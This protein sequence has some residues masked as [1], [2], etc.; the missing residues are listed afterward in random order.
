[1]F[2]SLSIVAPVLQTAF[3][4][5]YYLTDDLYLKS[6]KGFHAK[7]VKARRLKVSHNFTQNKYILKWHYWFGIYANELHYNEDW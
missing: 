2:A 3:S 6:L 4:V 5:R 1:M 7:A